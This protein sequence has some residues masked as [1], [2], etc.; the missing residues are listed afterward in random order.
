M[1]M[2]ARQFSGLFRRSS[3]ADKPLPEPEPI[4]TSRPMTSFF[5]SLTDEQKAKLRAYRGDESHGEDDFR[6]QQAA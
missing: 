2:L 4:Y 5:A 1:E 6:R 3:F